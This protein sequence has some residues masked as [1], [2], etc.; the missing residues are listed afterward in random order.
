MPLYRDELFRAALFLSGV[1]W[2][3]M[4]FSI[5]EARLV[6]C[7]GNRWKMTY[8]LPRYQ[9]SGIDGTQSG[10]QPSAPG[11][12]T[13]HPYPSC[14]GLRNLGPQKRVRKGARSSKGGPCAP[15]LSCS[16]SGW[17]AHWMQA[18]A[19]GINCGLVAPMHTG[20]GGH[21]ATKRQELNRDE[22]REMP[23]GGIKITLTNW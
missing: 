18:V 10:C 11:S 13:A 21:W 4:V 5:A 17:A 23:A 16:R 15:E 6:R 14:R 7:G 19:S 2:A 9:G 12:T 8:L 20:F 1:R 22:V 3:T